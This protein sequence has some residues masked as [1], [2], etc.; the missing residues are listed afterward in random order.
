[1]PENRSRQSRVH[2]DRFQLAKMGIRKRRPVHRRTALHWLFVCALNN[3]GCG[4]RERASPTKEGKN[5]VSVLGDEESD[6]AQLGKHI[7]HAVL[8]RGQVCLGGRFLGV[9]FGI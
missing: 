9:P 5:I 4:S 3:G 6:S 1:M 8:N 2:K 7:L